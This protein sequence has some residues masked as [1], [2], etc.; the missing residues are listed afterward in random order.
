[1]KNSPHDKALRARLGPSKFSAQGFMGSDTR[2]VEEIIA[3]D[4]RWMEQVGITVEKIADDLGEAYR[5]GREALGGTVDLG[6]GRTAVYHESMGR[7]AS[8]FRGDGV[9]E[10]G[11]V[12]VTDTKNGLQLRLTALGIHLIR[13]HG[14]F[15]GRGSAYRI[16]PPEAVRVLRL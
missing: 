5:R 6:D 1:M 11:E 4:R 12:V 8:P 2:T 13:R 9:F 10:K 14:F 7:V 15:Q 16:E 3:E